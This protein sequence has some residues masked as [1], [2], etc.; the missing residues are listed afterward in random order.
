MNISFELTCLKSIKVCALSALKVVLLFWVLEHLL[1]SVSTIFGILALSYFNSIPV[2]ARSCEIHQ[3]ELFA[4]PT[5]LVTLY[6]LLRQHC[7]S[8]KFL[9]I[10]YV[11]SN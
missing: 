5:L 4:E 8:C 7:K 2:A 10:H 11:Y 3:T 1:F 6:I 9:R